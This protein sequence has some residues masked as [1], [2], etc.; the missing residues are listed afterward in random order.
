M[1]EEKTTGFVFGLISLILAAAFVAYYVLMMSG[2][3]YL[4]VL[5]VILPVVI[6][7]LSVIGIFTSI[8]YI[9]KKINI[10]GLILSI[11]SFIT[12][13]LGILVSVLFLT[14]ISL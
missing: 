11:L 9:R 14:S 2:Y 6:F 8:K 7:I 5:M 12:G 4:T 3:L 13:A 10:L 1:K